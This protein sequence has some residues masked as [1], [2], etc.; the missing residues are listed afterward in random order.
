MLNISDHPKMAKA[1][2]S[3][4]TTLSPASLEENTEM[5]RMRAWLAERINLG[6]PV[7]EVVTLTPILAGLLLERNKENR[8]VSQ[9]NLDRLKSDLKGGRYV[10]NGEAI[11]ISA[12]GDLNDGQHRCMA[13]R[14]TGKSL[15]TVMVFGPARETRMTLD[16]GVLRSAG[17]YLSMAGFTDTNYLAGVAKLVWQFRTFNKVSNSIRDYPT[18]TQ[19][20]DVVMHYRD[21]VDSL[22]F[23][24]RKGATVLGSRS[25]LGFCH[26]AMCH[27]NSREMADE[28]FEKLFTGAGLNIG[29]P[30]LYCR[31]RLIELKGNPKLHDKAELVFR[32]WNSWRKG[33]PVKFVRITGTHFPELE[34]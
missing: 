30:I 33:E 20:T 18:K 3:N 1:K 12:S 28:F 27:A 17:H 22:A 31:N 23:V 4:P 25:F 9:T 32:S 13:V 14:E 7:S 10:F 21:I 15:R 11:I 34:R 29:S 24:S 19:L 26:W 2:A 6:E 5:K 16:Q 8:P